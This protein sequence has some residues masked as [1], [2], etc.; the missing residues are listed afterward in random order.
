MRAFLFVLSCLL[1]VPFAAAQKLPAK[2]FLRGGLAPAKIEKNILLNLRYIPPASLAA[3]SAFQTAKTAVVK[4]PVRNEQEVADFSPLQRTIARQTLGGLQAPAETTSLAQTEKHIRASLVEVVGRASG[5]LMGSGFVVQSRSGRLYAVVSYHVVGRKGNTVAVRTYPEKGA[6]VVYNGLIVNA[7]GSFGINAPDAAIIALPQEAQAY[8]RP[9]TIAPS[10]PEKGSELVVWGSP[11][12]CEGFARIDEL[13]VTLAQGIKMVMDS[14]DVS[15]EFNG[16]CGSPVLNAQG[17][18][19]G[20]YSGHDPEQGQVFAV[21]ARQAL[22]WLLESY[23]QGKLPAPLTYKVYGRDV[24]Q[25][26]A[27]ETIGWVYHF[28]QGGTLLHKVYLPKYNG[29]FD[30]EHAEWLFPDVQ[31]GD[32]L[33]FEIVKHRFVD[34]TVSVGIS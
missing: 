14:P 23:E 4:P 33:E 10:L 19:A 26:Q 16:L 22:E 9:L 24:L 29:R 20:I 5:D 21:N 18:V 11:Y 17:Q 31:H 7:A 34:R 32:F 2:N 13:K 25:I 12:A 15:E 30:P 1:T 28:D 27:E 8:V 3:Q 6:P